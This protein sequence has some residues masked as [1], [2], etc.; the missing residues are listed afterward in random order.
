MTVFAQPVCVPTDEPWYSCYSHTK[1]QQKKTSFFPFSIETAR[2][3]SQGY[4]FFKEISEA[5]L[6]G[7]R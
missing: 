1:S 6:G 2:I 5:E 7:K 4:V 3:C